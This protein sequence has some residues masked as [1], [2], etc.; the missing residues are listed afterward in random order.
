MQAFQHSSDALAY[1]ALVFNNGNYE[2]L[3][4]HHSVIEASQQ[5]LVAA[6]NGVLAPVG[7]MLASSASDADV[8][9]S[10][11]A[12]VLEIHGVSHALVG[13]LCGADWNAVQTVSVVSRNGVEG[14]FQ[15]DLTGTPCSEVLS[16]SVC[17]YPRNVAD[18]FPDDVLLAQMGIECYVGL[19]LYDEGGRPLG[20]MIVMDQSPLAGD[21]IESVLYVMRRLSPLMRRVLE[22]RRRAQDMDMLLDVSRSE[23]LASLVM[24]MATVLMTRGSFLLS[25]KAASG[26]SALTFALDGHVEHVEGV[27]LEPELLQRA[28][29]GDF[30]VP[31]MMTDRFVADVGELWPQWCEHTLLCPLFDRFGEFIGVAGVVH[32]SPLNPRLIH[33]PI[34]RSFASHASF[35][36]EEAIYIMQ[37]RRAERRLHELERLESLGILIGGVAHDFNNVISG[38]LGNAEYLLGVADNEVQSEDVMEALFDIR[39]AANSASTLCKQLMSYAGRSP[40]SSEVFSLNSE[41]KAVSRLA[42]ATLG[43]SCPLEIAL[44]VKGLNICGDPL[45]V[46]QVVMNLLTNGQEAVG[47]DGVLVLTVDAER[48][49]QGRWLKGTGQLAPGHYALLTVTDNGCG[50]PEEVQ[51]RMFDPFFTTKMLGHGL[52]LSSVL[53]IVRSHGGGL[54][55]HSTPGQGTRIDVY[56]PVVSEHAQKAA[57]KLVE[58]L[59]LCEKSQGVKGKMLVVD[60]DEF[61]RG[62][63]LRFCKRANFDV[64][65]AESGES[66]VVQYEREPHDIAMIILDMKMPGMD[67]LETLE[68]LKKINPEV[69]VLMSSGHQR[70]FGDIP[71]LQKPYSY[72]TFI[73]AVTGLMQG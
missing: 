66:G 37:R 40:K 17:V 12:S 3:E 11:L 70:D 15:Y 68:Q 61:I 30:K 5:W 47:G 58:P 56:L 38:V 69:K 35:M 4:E 6:V 32:D 22:S 51:D 73:E 54:D 60:D 65:L 39:D 19:P 21:K 44:R 64:V 67:G 24:N 55:V 63:L 23:D 42:K 34:I 53:E 57:S 16:K 43:V 2:P 9:V 48:V 13:E 46:R 29:S 36:L 45:Q 72:Q 52:G 14:N 62:L 7:D 10:L 1:Y 50:I 59:S 25:L 8:L 18:L 20:L 49:T 27:S 26:Q 33:Q 31:E 28:R 41:V 71:V